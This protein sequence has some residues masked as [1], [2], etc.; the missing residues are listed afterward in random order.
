MKTLNFLLVAG[1][2]M[3]ANFTTA[4][5]GENEIKSM[6][7]SEFDQ[8]IKKSIKNIPFGEA[9]SQEDNS[10]I[11]LTFDVNDSLEMEN[12]QV[13]GSNEYLVQ[14]IQKVL[15]TKKFKVH[16]YFIGKH[17]SV[18]IRVIDEGR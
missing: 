8:Q 2:I 15:E 13:A 18:P 14:S 4:K 16:P 1:L 9:C 6:A 12:I 10:I 17:C 5:A 7:I 11:V 3:T